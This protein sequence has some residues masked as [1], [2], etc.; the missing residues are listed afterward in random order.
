ML[1]ENE[2]IK[3]LENLSQ[4]RISKCVHEKTAVVIVDMVN[5]FLKCGNLH[6]ENSM[7]IVADIKQLL[8][9][10]RDKSMKTIMFADCHEKNSPELSYFPEHC[11]CGTQECDVIDELAQ[12]GGYELIYKNSTNGFHETEFKKFLEDNC[13]IENFIVCGV[14]TDI[15]VMN[16]CLTLKTFFDSRNVESHVILPVGLTETYGGEFVKR[17]ACVLMN[18][19]GIELFGGIDFD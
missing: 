7:R 16:F 12:I 2:L 5:G 3:N 4:Y 13:H 6:D 18:N 14:C 15:C 1:S 19:S 17:A 10:C 11:V 8:E 9:Y